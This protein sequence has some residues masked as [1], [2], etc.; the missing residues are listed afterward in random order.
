MNNSMLKYLMERGLAQ[1]YKHGV[2]RFHGMHGIDCPFK[3]E[4]FVLSKSCKNCAH[5]VKITDLFD[6]EAEDSN[7]PIAHVH[8]DYC[9][10]D[11]YVCAFE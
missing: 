10:G 2:I 11:N 5:C 8:C 1:Q 4:T 6:R 7:L 3:P 9:L